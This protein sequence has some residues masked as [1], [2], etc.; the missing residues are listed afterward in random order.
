MA[1]LKMGGKKQ[2]KKNFE[3]FPEKPGE[4]LTGLKTEVS[5]LGSKT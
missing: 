3:R 1:V 5:A 2:P 4:L